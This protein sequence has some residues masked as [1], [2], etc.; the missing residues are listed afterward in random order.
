MIFK[1]TLTAALIAAGS[2]TCFATAAQT[3][4]FAAT[5]T[6][7]SATK[8]TA[9]NGTD[10]K[11]ADNT[12][13]TTDTTGK[14]TT[15]TSKTTSGNT[16]KKTSTST[17]KTTSG[18]STNKT[19]TPKTV[20]VNIEGKNVEVPEKGN[21]WIYLNG[22]FH[23]VKDGKLIKGW[24]YFT[25]ADGQD[26]NHFSFFDYTNGRLYTGWKYMGSKEGEKTAHWSYFGSN[27]WLRTGW[28]MM[29]TSKNPDGNSKV[30]WSYFGA[31]G[32]L[33][34]GWQ[35]MGTK[36]NP[37]GNNKVHW[38][39]FG[40][41]GWMVKGWYTNNDGLHYFDGSGWMQASRTTRIEGSDYKFSEN[42]IVIGV[43][44]S[45]FK[46]VNQYKTY[47]YYP[48]SC[49]SSS[50]LMAMQA[51]GYCKGIDTKGEYEDYLSTW[52]A[53]CGSS[54]GKKGGVGCSTPGNA[55]KVINNENTTRGVPVKSVTGS[56]LNANYLKD[57]LTHGQTSM[58]IIQNF[59]VYTHWIAITGWEMNGK[60]LV[61][62]IAD[63]LPND[64][65][66]GAY[67]SASRVSQGNL[68][69]S[70]KNSTLFS[71]TDAGIVRQYHGGR[72]GVTF[73]NYK[74]LNSYF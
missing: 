17:S 62:K 70:M 68:G 74:G 11:S 55:V 32:W 28:Q 29:G 14:T 45:D 12:K 24:R 30:H 52:R 50:A 21:N 40:P 48:M 2:I 56:A 53:V 36:T 71:L 59:K 57:S 66:S 33:R 9:T 51:V 1:K 6:A 60:E 20:K 16:T 72:C 13:K 19:T 67:S 73:G 58:V 15:N 43:N 18:N 10:K 39:Y 27:G 46:Y 22:Y 5:Q 3:D 4:T 49:G 44:H 38:S 41:N 69:T 34:T 64:C 61:F 63:P 25:K 8:T 7:T 47:G 31:D 35:R 26:T 42:G 54:F 65:G 37:D 23:F